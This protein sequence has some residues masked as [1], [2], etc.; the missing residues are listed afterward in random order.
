VTEE[1]PLRR[2]C[3]R[4]TALAA[5]N[6]AFLSS[7]STAAVGRN[8]TSGAGPLRLHAPRAAP[9]AAVTNNAAQNLDTILHSLFDVPRREAPHALRDHEPIC[10]GAR[11]TPPSASLPNT[12]ALMQARLEG[13]FWREPMNVWCQGIPPN[14]TL[15][16]DNRDKERL[17]QGTRRVPMPQARIRRR[18]PSQFRDAK[19]RCAG[20]RAPAGLV[21]PTLK[22]GVQNET[23][24]P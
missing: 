6:A 4:Q 3:S 13:T 14:A 23:F 2:A 20:Y 17:Y 22:R 8:E 7:P 1:I 15:V 12:A 21:R 10:H 16:A 19:P 18:R 9:K 24:G 5:S 11:T